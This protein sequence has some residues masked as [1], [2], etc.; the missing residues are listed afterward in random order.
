MTLDQLL[1]RLSG[2]TTSF[3]AALGEVSKAPG[4]D[5]LSRL[6]VRLESEEFP[7]ATE[8]ERRFATVFRRVS[9]RSADLAAVARAAEKLESAVL[10]NAVTQLLP[11]EYKRLAFRS[12]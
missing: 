2:P 8:R 11:P 5:L 4:V 10:R 1:D 6:M 3:E 9:L 12:A 7:D